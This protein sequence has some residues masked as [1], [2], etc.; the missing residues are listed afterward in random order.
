MAGF[1]YLHEFFLKTYPFSNPP[2]IPLSKGGIRFLV[3]DL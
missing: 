3:F 1:F 2:C